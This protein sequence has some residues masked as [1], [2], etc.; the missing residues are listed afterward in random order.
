MNWQPNFISISVLFAVI[1]TP[2]VANA[3]DSKFEWSGEL[4]AGYLY[5]SNVNVRELDQNTERADN[6]LHLA[7]K[8]NVR[9]QPWQKVEVRLGAQHSETNYQ[10][11]EDFDLAL[12]TFNGDLSYDFGVVK[13][14]LSRHS[15]SAELA[16][17]DFLDY[18]HDTLYLSRLWNPQWFT[19]IARD[20]IDKEFSDLAERNAQAKALAADIYWFTPSAKSFINLGYTDHD[21]NAQ[22]AQFSYAGQSIRVTW[23]TKHTLW[24]AEHSWQ[25][26]WQLEN[27]DYQQTIN[28]IEEPRKEQRQALKAKWQLPI[29][30]HVRLIPQLEYVDND[31]N[32]AD[33]DYQE[34]AA[35]VHL[36]LHF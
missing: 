9:W 29:G 22:D 11:F 5:D 13:A 16:D 6:A 24:G 30:S 8:F 2:A 20:K 21:E 25:L 7:G 36:S 10:E 14:G 26:G 12:T 28:A 27:R 18:Q 4:K 32:V 33:V 34:T 19:R 3:A 1:T 35:S 23:Q 17:S 15:A 31:S